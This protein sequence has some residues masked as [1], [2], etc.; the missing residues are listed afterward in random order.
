[1]IAIGG[2]GFIPARIIRT[3][4][5]VSDSPE[6]KPRNIPIQAIGL[7]LYEALPDTSE[8]VVGK[9]VIRTQWLDFSTLGDKNTKYG[10]LLG[11]RI[12]V[13]DEVD[14]RWVGSRRGRVL[15]CP[16]MTTSWLLSTLRL[17]PRLVSSRPPQPNTRRPAS[18]A[19]LS[20]AL[21]ELQIDVE[22]Q[23]KELKVSEE[24]RSRIREATKFGIFVVHNKWVSS[25]S[26]TD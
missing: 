25:T 5:K 21:Q 17:H 9:E 2:G 7:S 24:E 1:M 16:S 20:Y 10:G 8:E 3:F 12:L 14:D 15:L 6:S 26:T 13:V 18:R 4:L 22:K 11:K 23:L 19:T